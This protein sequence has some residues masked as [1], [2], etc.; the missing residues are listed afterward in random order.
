M[1]L[2][3]KGLLAG[4]CRSATAVGVVRVG[5]VSSGKKDALVS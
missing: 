4:I 3:P 2:E 5:D 1:H